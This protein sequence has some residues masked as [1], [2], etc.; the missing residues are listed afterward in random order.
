MA[1][2]AMF[3]DTILVDYRKVASDVV[4]QFLAKNQA[5]FGLITEKT[6]PGSACNLYE[7]Y[8]EAINNRQLTIDSE[9]I[10]ECEDSFQAGFNANLQLIQRN[11]PPASILVTS[12]QLT[13]GVIASARLF[14]IPLEPSTSYVG[15]SANHIF[16]LDSLPIMVVKQP[17]VRM[18]RAGCALMI[19]RVNQDRTGFPASMYFEAILSREL[20]AS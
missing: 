6:Q 12:P 18:A 13:L 17:L 20:P 4:E 8:R 10:L 3:F 14:G 16:Q 2:H 5:R 9:Q 19:S 7:S 11:D 1:L 15:F